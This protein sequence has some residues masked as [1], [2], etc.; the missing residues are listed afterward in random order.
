MI[1]HIFVQC[2]YCQ[3]KILLRFQMGYFDIPFDICCPECEVHICGVQ[4]IVDDHTL[5]IKNASIIDEDLEG[6]GLLC[7]FFCRVTARKNSPF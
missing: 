2:N 4:K 7:R 3:K 1:G 6:G 5:T